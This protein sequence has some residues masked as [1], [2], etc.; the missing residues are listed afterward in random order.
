MT[1]KSVLLF[2]KRLL[3]YSETFIAA[4]GRAVEALEPVFVGFTKDLGG[5]DY[6]GD[7]PVLLHSELARSAPL[8]RTLMRLSGR[9]SPRWLRAMASTEPALFHAHFGRD[10]L[11]ALPIVDRLRVP[12]VVTFWGFD[13][14]MNE[15]RTRYARNRPRVFARAAVI[16]ACSSFIR[17]QLIA[18]SCPP[19]KVVVHHVGIDVDRFSP[20]PDLPRQPRVLFV[21]RLVAK[22]GLE[23]LI[24]AMA[25][26]QD[27]HPDAELVVAGDGPLRGDLERLAA[28]QLRKYIYLGRQ[29]PAQVRSL[30]SSAQV[31]CVPS[32]VAPSGDAEGLPLVVLE[33]MAMGLPVVS[34]AP[35]GVT[36]AI[37]D[38][39]TGFL[40]RERDEDELAAHLG[41]ALGD[42]ELCRRM[43]YAGRARVLEHFDLK[44]Q[45]AY[46]EGIYEEVLAATAGPNQQG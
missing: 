30:M 36:D 12:L 39:V 18:K 27:R 7:A 16:V 4:Q 20:D 21:G 44:K 40:A 9:V 35:G 41:R 15:T 2:R 38:G 1:G 10:A 6:L 22:K 13:I 24:R 45:T 42:P 14:T 34:F 29:T 11:A 46:L 28:S 17:D 43:G 8:S 23:Y 32:V 37:Q 26:I 31:S 19:E 3:P 25:R 5:Y 33:A